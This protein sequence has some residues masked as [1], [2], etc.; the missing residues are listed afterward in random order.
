MWILKGKDLHSGIPNGVSFRIMSHTLNDKKLASRLL[1]KVRTLSFKF[2]CFLKFF[3]TLYSSLLTFLSY[4]MIIAFLNCFCLHGRSMYTKLLGLNLQVYQIWLIGQ[5]E[6]DSPF[7]VLQMPMVW[8][9]LH[10]SDA[11]VVHRLYRI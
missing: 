3:S 7:H 10:N 4:L 5:L 1:N 6:L 2:I 8:V 11:N 9:P